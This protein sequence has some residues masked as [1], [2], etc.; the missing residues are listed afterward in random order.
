MED[1]TKS[2]EDRVNIIK[3]IKFKYS[4]ELKN[5]E[6]IEWTDDNIKEQNDI[7][8]KKIFGE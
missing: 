6:P 7:F 3:D 5:V 2:F 1:I 8:L 4:K